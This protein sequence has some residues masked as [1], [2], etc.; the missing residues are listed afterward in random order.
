MGVSSVTGPGRCGT[1][2]CMLL[3]LIWLIVV[4]Q[5]RGSASGCRSAPALSHGFGKGSCEEPD[6]PTSHLQPDF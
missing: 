2:S 3:K 1:E 5:A 6:L 4:P